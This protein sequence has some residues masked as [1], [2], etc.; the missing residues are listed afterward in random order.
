MNIEAPGI[1][2]NVDKGTRILAS[3]LAVQIIVTIVVQAFLTYT[4]TG[5][6]IASIGSAIWSWLYLIVFRWLLWAILIWRIRMQS[7][8]CRAVLVFLLIWNF[9]TSL[10]DITRSAYRLQPSMPAFVRLLVPSS[11]GV[12]ILYVIA[13]V[14]LYSPSASAWFKLRLRGGLPNAPE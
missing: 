8:F 2:E 14:Y 6:Q 11:V 12:E 1:P 4:I 13:F 3:A 9:I 5:Y 10:G 7:A